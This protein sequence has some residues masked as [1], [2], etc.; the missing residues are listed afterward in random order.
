MYA[1]MGVVATKVG[2][3][4]RREYLKAILKQDASWFESFDILELPSRVSKETL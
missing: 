2:Y 1:F 3:Y 4:Y